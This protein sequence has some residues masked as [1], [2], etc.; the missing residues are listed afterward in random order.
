MAMWC[1]VTWCTAVETWCRVAL[2]CTAVEVAAEA[3]EA[4]KAAIGRT[5]PNR[6]YRY[7]R[8]VVTGVAPKQK[9]LREKVN[10]RV[11]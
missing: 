9:A 8:E 11:E 1:R 7:L 3:E 10:R 2:W 6:A 4:L 5:R